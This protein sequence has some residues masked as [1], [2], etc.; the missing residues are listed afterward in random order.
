MDE[1]KPLTFF[2]ALRAPE[3]WLL[4]GTAAAGV[5]SGAAWV[6]IPLCVAGLSISALPKY[7]EL[8]PRAEKIG[9]AGE[10]WK[11]VALSLFNSTAA[12]SAAF[13]LGQV[14]RLVFW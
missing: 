9:A 4:L 8:W 13:V 11:T 7:I 6:F 14:A 10:W 12:A 2:R 1:G 3:F 5:A